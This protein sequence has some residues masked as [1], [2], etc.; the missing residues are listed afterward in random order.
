MPFSDELV[1][2]VMAAALAE[3]AIEAKNPLAYLTWRGSAYLSIDPDDG[4]IYAA[5]LA[6]AKEMVATALALTGEEL[7]RIGHK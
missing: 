5:A 2:E 4:K 7:A 3:V 6:R 1:A